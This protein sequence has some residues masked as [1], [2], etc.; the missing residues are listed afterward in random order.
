MD[1]KLSFRGW[2]FYNYLIFGAKSLYQF[3]DAFFMK[4]LNQMC[5]FKDL[6]ERFVEIVLYIGKGCGERKLV[7]LKE[8]KKFLSQKEKKR[9]VL[10]N[11]LEIA[12]LLECGDGVVCFETYNYMAT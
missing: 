3:I 11:T 10:N 8:A 5:I 1:G 7:H 12:Q 6:V 4:D 2:K 9:G